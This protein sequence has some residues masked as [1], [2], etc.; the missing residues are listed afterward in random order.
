[1]DTVTKDLTI[2]DLAL[3]RPSTEIAIHLCHPER[4]DIKKL[5]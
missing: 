3:T 2:Q 1:L 5:Y 4:S